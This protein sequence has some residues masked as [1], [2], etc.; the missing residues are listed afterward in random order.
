MNVYDYVFRVYIHI[1]LFIFHIYICVP[2]VHRRVFTYTHFCVPTKRVF[3]LTRICCQ[4]NARVCL[5]FCVHI[6]VCIHVCNIYV[7]IPLCICVYSYMHIYVP[8]VPIYIYICIHVVHIY[9]YLCVY[10]CVLI[11]CMCVPREHMFV[12][13]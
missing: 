4:M 13:R 9:V 10:M 3:V 1:Y 5:G 2:L 8:R 11:R 12:F 7:C 6:N